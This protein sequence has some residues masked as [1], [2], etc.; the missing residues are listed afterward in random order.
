MLESGLS[1]SV[2]GVPSNGHPYRDPRPLAAISIRHAPLADRTAVTPRISL[3]LTSCAIRSLWY[4]FEAA[5]DVFRMLVFWGRTSI[6][7]LV[8]R[9]RVVCPHH[10]PFR[11]G[12]CRRCDFAEYE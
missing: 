11:R 6:E 12:A 5:D 2:R 1:G 7:P 3:S 4:L 9:P 10:N 8:P